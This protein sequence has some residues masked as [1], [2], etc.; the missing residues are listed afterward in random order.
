MKLNIIPRN[1]IYFELFNKAT[2]NLTEAARLLR[3][4]LKNPE[5]APANA[6]AINELEHRGDDIVAEITQKLAKT[7]V[8]PFDPEDIHELKSIIDSILDSID[9]IAERITLYNVKEIPKPAIELAQELVNSVKI[10][11]KLASCLKKMQ[12]CDHNL[13]KELKSCES[14]A[15]KT[16]RR[17]IADLFSNGFEVIEVIKWKDLYEDLEDAVDFCHEAAI[18]IEG[19]I[20]KYA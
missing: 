14:V 12:L 8:T 19:I 10:L 6:K 13:V 7:F 1:D 18:T 9:S 5:K 15:D 16:Y 17:A 11:T 2:E 3:D 4:M 20:L